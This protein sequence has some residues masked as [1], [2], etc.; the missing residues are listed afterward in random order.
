MSLSGEPS[1]PSSGNVT[2]ARSDESFASVEPSAEET[3]LS[4]FMA[5]RPKFVRG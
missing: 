4:W 2:V 5:G 1:C 3:P